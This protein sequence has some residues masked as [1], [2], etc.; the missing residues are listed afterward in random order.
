MQHEQI[1]LSDPAWRR[2]RAAEVRG[3]ARARTLHVIACFG[4][5]VIGFGFGELFWCVRPITLVVCSS[6]MFG[7]VS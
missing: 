6:L 1:G 7:E 3:Q 2:A 4:L 5:A